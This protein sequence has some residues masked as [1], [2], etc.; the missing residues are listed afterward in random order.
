[1]LDLTKNAKAVDDQERRIR[2]IENTLIEIRAQMQV[3][4]SNAKLA[5]VEK[6]TEAAASLI[7][8]VHGPLVNEV[9]ALRTEIDRLQD[10]AEGPGAPPS[11]IE[12]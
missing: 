9:A 8:S 2:D 6:A 3:D 11:R 4:A 5:A 7:S 10:G 12:G 1:M